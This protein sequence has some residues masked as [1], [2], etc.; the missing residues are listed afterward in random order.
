MTFK[1]VGCGSGWKSKAMLSKD[2]LCIDCTIYEEERS[3]VVKPFPD[4]KKTIPLIPPGTIVKVVTSLSGAFNGQ[5]FKVKRYAKGF[6]YTLQFLD[7]K[8]EVCWFSDHQ[9]EIQR[10]E[11]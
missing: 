5:I 7:K 6:G 10:G 4:L 2:G 11:S 1:C 8:D 3:D 9:L